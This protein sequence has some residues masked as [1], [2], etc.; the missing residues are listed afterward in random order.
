MH[1]S[2]SALS[3]LERKA[4][5]GSSDHTTAGRPLIVLLNPTTSLHWVL[6]A[7]VTVSVNFFTNFWADHIQRCW[8]H[9]VHRYK[10]WF[11]AQVQGG[12]SCRRTC[13]PTSHPGFWIKC[14]FSE[15]TVSCR[16]W[17]QSLVSAALFQNSI[18]PARRRSSVLAMS[19][20]WV[21]QSIRCVLWAKRTLY[22]WN[23]LTTAVQVNLTG[24]FPPIVTPFNEDESI[25]WDMLRGNLA[26]W[27]KIRKQCHDEVITNLINNLKAVNKSW[28]Q[29]EKGATGWVPSARQQRGVCLPDRQG[30]GRGHPGG[31][32][33]GAPWQFLQFLSVAVQVGEGQLVLAG[34]G[35]ESTCETIEMTSA[36]A[37]KVKQ[38]F[39]KTCDKTH[40]ISYDFDI[41]L[42][43]LL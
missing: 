32:G 36:M 8:V 29:V 11:T 23:K 43:W 19:P 40:E 24:I 21:L 22:Q 38:S 5:S 34:S 30:E 14:V 12:L 4:P 25:A 18:V 27:P 41:P 39:K 1:L 33:G 13:P 7:S 6:V 16:K 26:R 15:R 10:N 9:C 3:S 35:C 37:G 17:P 28:V 31:Q 2:F 42:S 20:Q